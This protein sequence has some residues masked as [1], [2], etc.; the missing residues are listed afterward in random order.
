MVIYNWARVINEHLTEEYKSGNARQ[1][2]V[3]HRNNDAFYKFSIQF[4]CS[5]GVIWSEML[6]PMCMSPVLLEFIKKK[7]N[8]KT[9]EEIELDFKNFETRTVKIFLDALYGC[10]S[11][12]CDTEDLIKLLALVDEHGS[13][14]EGDLMLGDRRDHLIMRLQSVFQMIW[15][16]LPFSVPKSQKITNWIQIT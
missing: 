7:P 1:L 9:A 8:W 10:G 16:D 2:K 15:N 14:K 6:V 11:E 5:D 3:T 12:D 13:D 4:I